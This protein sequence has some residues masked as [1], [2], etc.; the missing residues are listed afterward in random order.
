MSHRHDA[1]GDEE[2]EAERGGTARFARRVV[3]TISEKTSV[4]FKILVPVCS[5]LIFSTWRI[6]TGISRLQST[7]DKSWTI[8]HQEVFSRQ[9]R[10]DNPTLNVP[11]AR[12]IFDS[13]PNINLIP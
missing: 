12:E 8:T 9:L 3:G 1:R 13:R 5:L 10:R 7:L 11:D 2:G 6:S 4:P